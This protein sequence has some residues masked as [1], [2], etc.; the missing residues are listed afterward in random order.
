LLDIVAE[1][2]GPITPAEAATIDGVL[3]ALAASP[4]KLDGVFAHIEPVR[5]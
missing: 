3:T 2:D 1:S 4:K 5:R